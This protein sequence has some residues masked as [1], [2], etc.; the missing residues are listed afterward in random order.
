MAAAPDGDFV[1]VGRNFSSGGNPIAI[2]I[3]RFATDGTLLWR[4][5][6]ARTFPGVGRLI[7]DSAGSAYLAFNSLGDGQDIQLHKYSPFGELLWAQVINTGFMAN[8]IT[9]TVILRDR[10][11]A[12]PRGLP[13][14]TTR[15]PASVDGW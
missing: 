2:T 6:L 10:S 14:H 5:D 11:P 1:A 9:S 13:P 8:D 7:V 4:V 15:R 12:A 3:V